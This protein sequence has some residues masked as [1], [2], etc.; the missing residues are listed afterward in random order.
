MPRH[1]AA[2]PWRREQRARWGPGSR[3]PC[4]ARPPV[5]PMQESQESETQG[6]GMGGRGGGCRSDHP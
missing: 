6:P 2:V 4:G 1:T 3:R 5:F